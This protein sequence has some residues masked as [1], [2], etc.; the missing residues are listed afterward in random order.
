MT[1]FVIQ[2]GQP[3]KAGD[4]LG[5]IDSEGADKLIGEIDEFYLSRLAVGQLAT[6][7][8]EGREVRLTVDRVLPQVVNGRFKVELVFAGATPAGLRRGQTVDA[9]I[10]LG[11]A[12]LAIVAPNGPWLDAGGTTAFVVSGSRAVRRPVTT[13]RRTPEQVEITGGLHPG[14]RI[15]T[16]GIAAYRTAT[17]LIL[18]EGNH[19]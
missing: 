15:V 17:S 8:I 10:T 11:D 7:T 13:G 6:A 14:E 1:G 18:R 19:E 2:P 9:R 16:S 4:P 3:I 5:Q 12:K